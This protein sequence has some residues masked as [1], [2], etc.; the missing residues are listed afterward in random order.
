[1]IFFKNWVRLFSKM[2]FLKFILVE[3]IFI[4]IILVTYTYHFINVYFFFFDA[5]YSNG[6]VLL[7]MS[8]VFSLGT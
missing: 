4:H 1:M 3:N 2:Q 7:D 5:I 8:Y 6:C